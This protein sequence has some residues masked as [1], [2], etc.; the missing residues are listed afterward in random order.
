MASAYFK[1]KSFQRKAGKLDLSR[2]Q[3]G[4]GTAKIL[5]GG[6][7]LVMPWTLP[8]LLGPRLCAVQRLRSKPGLLPRCLPD[9]VPSV[10]PWSFKVQAGRSLRKGRLYLPGV[11]KYVLFLHFPVRC[12]P[13]SPPVVG[14][15]PN[16]MGIYMLRSQKCQRVLNI[17][18]TEIYIRLCN[19]QSAL[20]YVSFDS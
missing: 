13:C 16:W 9:P 15:P 3:V 11:S 14:F 7:C 10:T 1:C 12:R 20:E 18:I 17:S 5:P 2:F 4:W 19:L 8:L 6:A